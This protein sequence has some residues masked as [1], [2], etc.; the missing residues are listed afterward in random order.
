MAGGRQP[1]ANQSEE[2]LSLVKDTSYT[3]RLL[4][5]FRAERE[6]RE[7]IGQP[8]PKLRE[9]IAYLLL[10]RGRPHQRE[11]IAAALWPNSTTA[12]SKTYLRHSLWQINKSSSKCSEIGWLSVDAEWIQVEVSRCWVD[13]AELERAYERIRRISS[14]EMEESDVFALQH[15]IALF[16]G[17]LLD[18][19]YQDW[20]ITERNRIR[21]IYIYLL[22]KLLMHWE[23][24]GDAGE[25][26]PL[27]ELLLREEPAHEQAHRALM[28]L[29]HHRGNRTAALRQFER[30][31][32]ALE[33]EFDI[34]PS[35]ST[36]NL[37]EQI[38]A[39]RKSNEKF[40]EAFQEVQPPRYG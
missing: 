2:I 15:G 10:F 14:L 31:R 35:R 19:H 4:G 11:A 30:C 8:S 37:L 1:P 38:R 6:G 22:E 12:Q 5:R 20:C 40:P 32:G 33:R 9:L 26:V 18:G 25:G 7:W 16:G 3:F 27:G 34:R 13:V 17:D 39:D 28:R 21:R 36:I 24:S 23:M 29:H